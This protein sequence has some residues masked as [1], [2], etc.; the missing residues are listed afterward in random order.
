MA[1]R[2]RAGVRREVCSDRVVIPVL[3]C[4]LGARAQAIVAVGAGLCH[5]RATEGL[6]RHVFHRVCGRVLAKA[7]RAVGEPAG[8]DHAHA[9]GGLSAVA[10]RGLM[11]S[12]GDQL[13]PDV[14][15]LNFVDLRKSGS[16][17]ALGAPTLNPLNLSAIRRRGGVVGHRF[18][19]CWRHRHRGET[20]HG[21]RPVTSRREQLSGISC[22]ITAVFGPR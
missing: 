10:A 22:G 8:L 5:D 14:L 2:L 9:S 21:R 17:A 11:T 6:R 4:C 1:E 7:D 16:L 15:K 13:A 3:E 19:C 20:T 18:H 12:G